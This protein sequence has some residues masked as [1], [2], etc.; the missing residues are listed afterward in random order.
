ML[1]KCLEIKEQFLK[2]IK[3]NQPNCRLFYDEFIKCW[4]G[5]SKK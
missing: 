4:Y 1:E 3:T 5:L 2:C